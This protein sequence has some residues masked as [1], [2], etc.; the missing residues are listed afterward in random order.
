M[1]LP[2][3]RSLRLCLWLILGLLLTL[4]WSSGGSFIPAPAQTAP[5]PLYQ[6][7]E[8]AYEQ[9]DYEGAIAHWETL[10]AETQ[11]I[12]QRASLLN[13]LSLAHQNLQNWDAAQQA[14]LQSLESLGWEETRSNRTPQRTSLALGRSLDVYGQWWERQ[15]QTETALGLW[16]QAEQQYRQHL[17][18]PSALEDW[19]R[20]QLYQARA[21]QYLGRHLD[22]Q[23]RLTGLYQA[24]QTE[25]DRL[26]PALRV[27]LAI[28]L[29]RTLRLIGTLDSSPD[30]LSALG[31]LQAAQVL[32][33]QQAP[34]RLSALH[35]ELG[36]VYR[37]IAER[38]LAIQ[39]KPRALENR[40]R[41]IAAYDQAVAMASTPL[42]GLQAQL[43]SLSFMAKH[44]HRATD[45]AP[46]PEDLTT[47]VRQIYPQIQALPSQDRPSIAARIHFAH[48]LIPLLQTHPSLPPS[49]ADLVQL[50]RTAVAAA[51][52]QNDRRLYSEATGILGR[53]YETAAPTPQHLA[54]AFRATDVALTTAQA[55]HRPELTYRWLWQLGK[56]QEKQGER[57]SAIAAY[58]AAV[59]TIQ[60][61]R[62]DLVILNPDVQFSFRDDIEPVYRE[63]ADLLLKADQPTQPSLRNAR[64]VIDSL[65]TLEVENYLRQSCS[66]ASL[67]AVDRVIDQFDSAAFLYSI[68][69]GDRLEVILKL[70]HQDQLL[71]HQTYQSPAWFETQIK[72]L[73]G[74]VEGP[75][76][77]DD[78]LQ[79]T[80]AAYSWFVEP[81]E[82]ALEEQ[83]VTTL[84]FVLDGV[85][86]DIPVAALFD[87]EQFLIQK[88]YAIALSPGLQLLSPQ[89][90]QEKD[91]SSVVMGLSEQRGDLP[92]HRDFPALR[93]VITE[94]ESI[95]STIPLAKVFLNQAF[96]SDTLRDVVVTDNSP[97][98]HIA[99]HGQFYADLEKTFILA[100][101]K[102]VNIRELGDILRPRDQN[103]PDPIELMI[104]SACQT[105]QGGGQA[106]LG[107]AGL[108]LQAGA[109][110]TIAS[111][112]IVDD[113]ATSNL[114]AT[115][116]HIL[117]T[118]KVTK[119]EA[120]RRAQV[121]LLEAGRPPYFWAAFI[122]LG[123]WL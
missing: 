4:L 20:N 22:A 81:F 32:A 54:D 10:L 95:Q 12:P 5:P 116:Y 115:F 8:D 59:E 41:A 58:T 69:L 107:L 67:E 68:V 91:I 74:A 47:L 43:N 90:M 66:I 28:D 49:R 14:I 24:I 55:I 42:Q 110:G 87:G 16:Q 65:Q 29:G 33:Q 3:R 101:D 18:Q 73:R 21:L 34:D 1:T 13:N 76:F 27:D 17:N 97:I 45:I 77:S 19:V 112:W 62:R 121:T 83:G 114:M 100:W 39:D 50:I 96:T 52:E 111:Q 86:R 106:A 122:S 92:T 72:Q 102:P 120:L 118:E 44:L 119:S 51:Q 113:R 104:L 64:Q 9:G 88:P 94:V 37:S 108:A 56:I 6:A 31:V 36:N 103:S 117:A 109:R 98:L 48:H 85:L 11:E 79:L 57:E 89:P 93:H 35:L 30:T 61:L 63:L 75:A 70:P 23:S 7:G 38:N 26:T 15:G 84:V 80:K 71:S 60:S 78:T 25:P 2:L 46:E 53:L 40:N 105:M 123:N 99:T 82:A